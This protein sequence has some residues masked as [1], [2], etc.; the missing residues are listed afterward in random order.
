[1][2]MIA[3][4]HPE[5]LTCPTVNPNF[6]WRVYNGEEQNAPLFAPAWVR[7]NC[8]QANCYTVAVQ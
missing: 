3:A 8:A 2:T 6:T 1:M 4:P 7:K 5:A